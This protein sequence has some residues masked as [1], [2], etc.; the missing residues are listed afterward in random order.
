MIDTCISPYIAALADYGVRRGLLEDADRAWAI[1]RLLA[2]LKL[3][4]ET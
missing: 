1:N 2:V 4:E 3:D